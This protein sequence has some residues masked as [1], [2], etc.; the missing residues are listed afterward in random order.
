MQI[1]PKGESFMKKKA[2]KKKF[3]FPDFDKMT[4]A[5]EAKWWDTHP[6]SEYWDELEDVDIVFEL[7]KPKT[8]TI[9]VRL[10]KNL[11]DRLERLASAKGL[12]VSTLARMWIAEKLRTNKA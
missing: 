1:S 2:N 6:F 11:K 9:V 10:Q 4:Y 3:K 8:E 7:H 12:N 5:Q